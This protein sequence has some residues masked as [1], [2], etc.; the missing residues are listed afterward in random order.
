MSY[1]AEA[2]EEVVCNFSQADEGEA[3]AE[4]EET[5]GTSNVRDPAHLLSLPEPFSVGFL[6]KKNVEFDLIEKRIGKRQI[7]LP[8]MNFLSSALKLSLSF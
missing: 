6:R 4:A 1:E 2:E 8:Y 3:H 5:A 7:F